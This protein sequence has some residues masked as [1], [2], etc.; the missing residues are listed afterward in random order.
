MKYLGICSNIRK[1]NEGDYL[2]GKMIHLAAEIPLPAFLDLFI[3]QELEE[4]LGGD[5]C[6]YHAQDPTA[7]ACLSLWGKS[8]CVFYQ[9]AGFEYIWL[10]K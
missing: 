10:F 7:R 6:S 1:D 2:W 9:N 8:A 5:F 4:V 3:L